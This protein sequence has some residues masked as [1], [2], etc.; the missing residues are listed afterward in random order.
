M[1]H[2]NILRQHEA[3]FKPFGPLGV[4]LFLLESCLET[5]SD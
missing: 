1:T 4:V 2:S 3:Q 5:M